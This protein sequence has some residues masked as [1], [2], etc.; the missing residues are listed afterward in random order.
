MYL[1]F[2]FLAQTISAKGFSNNEFGEAK[3]NIHYRELVCQEVIA[4]WITL[5]GSCMNAER[6]HRE[7]FSQEEAEAKLGKR[8]R[9]L[10]EFSGVPVGTAGNRYRD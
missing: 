7:Y 3:L 5:S 1:L 9:A 10:V 4:L 2:E 6:L 8:I